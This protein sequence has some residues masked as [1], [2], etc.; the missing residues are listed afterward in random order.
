[1]SLSVAGC[2]SHVVFK[3][4][5]YFC[6]FSWPIETWFYVLGILRFPLMAVVPLSAT[7]LWSVSGFLFCFFALIFCNAGV[8]FGHMKQVCH[9]PC[10]SRFVFRLASR[11]SKQVVEKVLLCVLLGECN[12]L[13]NIFGCNWILSHLFRS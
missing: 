12:F 10:I 9:C 3:F 6:V 5:F 1:M 2:L 4:L 7:H 11:H 8:N 13:P